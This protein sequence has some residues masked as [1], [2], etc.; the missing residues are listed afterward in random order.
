M[1]NSLIIALTFSAPLWFNSLVYAI[2]PLALTDPDWYPDGKRLVSD[3]IQTYQGIPTTAAIYTKLRGEPRSILDTL[4]SGHKLHKSWLYPHNYYN[5]ETAQLMA[6]G[7]WEVWKSV[8][9]LID[10]KGEVQVCFKR[11]RGE[12]YN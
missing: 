11:Q 12:F 8:W 9:L 2:E 4:F 3:P 6:D 10:N 7:S 1:L 5:F